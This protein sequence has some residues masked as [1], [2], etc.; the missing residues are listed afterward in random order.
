MGGRR[1]KSTRKL[2]AAAMCVAVGVVLLT[3]GSLVEVLDISMAVIASL[4]VVFGVIELRGKYPYLI[5]AA[6]SVL[7]LV[8]PLA[9]KTPALLYVCFAGFYPILKS[10]FEGHFSRM[11]AWV[12]KTAVFLVGG[13]IDI[14][15][16][17]KFFF[18]GELTYQ[19]WY[20]VLVLPLIVIFVLYDVAM[21]RLITAYMLRWR[22]RLGLRFED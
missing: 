12:L 4:G 10:V 1:N 16:M 8:L 20:P 17:L 21:T 19:S 2:T 5:Y 6:T 15:L 14:F 11:V 3:L 13:A 7:S 9:N 18:V 22:Q